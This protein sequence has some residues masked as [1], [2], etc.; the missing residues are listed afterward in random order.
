MKAVLNFDLDNPEDRSD[1]EI[2]NQAVK[3]YWVIWE[4]VTNYKRQMLKY[5]E[6]KYTGEQLEAIEEIFNH[7]FEELNNENINLEII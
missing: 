5:N 6:K 7:L 2:H 3:L 4:F 1:Y